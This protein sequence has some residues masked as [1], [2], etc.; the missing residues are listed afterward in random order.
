MNICIRTVVKNLK[1]KFPE[2]GPLEYFVHHNTLKHY[3]SMQFNEAVKKSSIEYNASAFMSERYFKK[4]YNKHNISEN[5]LY[6]SCEKYISLHKLDIPTELLVRLLLSDYD[7]TSSIQCDFSSFNNFTI[8]KNIFYNDIFK[9][10]YGINIAYIPQST[11]LRFLSS[12]FDY[13]SAFWS[14]PDRDTGIW[15]GFCGFHKHSS[16]FDSAFLKHLSKEIENISSNPILALENLLFRLKIPDSVLEDYLFSLLYRYKGWAGFI[17]S[18]EKHPDWIKKPHIMPSFDALTAIIVICELSVI[19]YKKF[20]LPNLPLITTVRQHSDSFINYFLKYIQNYPKYKQ[21]FISSISHLRDYDRQEIWHNAMEYSFY[22]TF[23]SSYK[24]TISINI[25]KEH[26]DDKS[27]LSKKYQIICCID[28]RE[29]SFRRYLE[30]D[31]NCETFGFAGHFGLNIR[32]K[33]Y[34]DK[35]ARALCPIT[36]KP[37]H[38]IIEKA[39]FINPTRLKSILIWG[40]LQWLSA[41]SS[42][43]LLRGIV[44]TCIGFVTQAIPFALDIISPKLTN[45]IKSKITKYINEAIHTEILYKKEC[46]T[47]GIEIN[48]RI[49]ICATLLKTIGLNK[50]VAPLVFIMGHGSS[51]LNNPHEAAHDCG[52]CGGGRGGPNARVMAAM[53][54][55]KDIQK[56]LLTRHGIKIPDTTVFIGSY[57]N[58]CNNL[59]TFYDLPT[60]LPDNLKQIISRIKI[61]SNLDAK[62]RSRR[63]ASI[64]FNKPPKYYAKKMQERAIDLRQPRPEYGHATN[65]ICIIG[66]RKV[67]RNMFLD[68]RAFLVSYDSESDENGSLLQALLNSAVPVCAGINLEY[69][70]SFVDNEVYGCGT[71]LPHNITSL[72]G[73]MN[74]YQSDLQLG[75]PWQMVE[76]HQPVRLLLLVVCDISLIKSA[77]CEKSEFSELI[78]NNWVNLVINDDKS[79]E[80]YIYSDGDFLSYNSEQTPQYYQRIDKH[81]FN[82]T[83]HINIGCLVK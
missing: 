64:P 36:A 44:Q 54:N 63:F 61:A 75:L 2:Q 11:I 83:E 26:K 24:N 74:G 20:I 27:P 35:H 19:E 53:L 15:N 17:K 7:S 38:E 42:K 23:L 9:Q 29:E 56:E 77:L 48:D 34:F 6:Q 50:S 57:H 12:Y 52:A 39:V 51:S 82:Q 32:F 62:E 59:V 73:V 47:N 40:E 13:G 22:N 76:I 68:R 46:N 31:K 14:M 33:S 30:S 80:L 10:Q 70:F 41:L 25:N 49:E 58:T 1:N 69:Y 65:A 79:G 78:N 16:R 28:D 18:L 66:P 67:T 5:S 55:E 43:R 81:I 71:K 8:K 60:K 4:E 21:N 45:K 37:E 3:Q 72:V